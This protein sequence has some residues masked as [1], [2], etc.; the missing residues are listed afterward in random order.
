MAVATIKGTA[1]A[2]GAGPA[3]PQRDAFKAAARAAK[4]AAREA[5]KDAAAKPAPQATAQS[6]SPATPQAGAEAKPA[7]TAN[8]VAPGT[9]SATPQPGLKPPLSDYTDVKPPGEQPKS[10]EAEIQNQV[11]HAKQTQAATRTQIDSARATLN[12]MPPGPAR[13]ALQAEVGNSE[14]QLKL[15]ERGMLTA[16]TDYGAKDSIIG[17]DGQP[18]NRGEV[19]GYTRISLEEMAAGP[20]RV[21]QADGSEKPVTLRPEMFN[22]ARGIN[23]YAGTD[24]RSALHNAALFRNDR[25]GTYT[26]VF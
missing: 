26:L 23:P 22:N 7:R 1:A 6:T 15:L 16:A 17:P 20:I 13:D 11:A 8:A 21:K 24:A 19:P 12:T 2:K 10:S 18:L 3:V 14:R 5:A 4:A 25:D 9:T